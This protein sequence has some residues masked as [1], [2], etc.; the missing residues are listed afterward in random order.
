M[1]TGYD[2]ARA[3][4]V[5]AATGRPIAVGEEFVATLIEGSQEER[6]E[7]ADYSVHAWRDGARPAKLYGYWRAKMESPEGRKRPYIDDAALMDLFEQLAEASE[8]GRVSFRYLLALMLVRKR[9]L[10]YEGTRRE[11]GAA[12]MLVRVATR[13]DQTPAPLVEVA[14]PGLNDSAIAEAIEQLTAVMADAR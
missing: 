5:C 3:T 7:R 6:L 10:K 1:A 4:G 13:A 11:G 8:P 9:L 12:V 14:D 2:I